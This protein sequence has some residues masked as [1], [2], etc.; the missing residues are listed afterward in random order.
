MSW[1]SVELEPEVGDWLDGLSGAEFG[2]V[3]FYVDLLAERGVLLSEPYTK[4]LDGKLRELRFDLGRQAIR[5]T[6][7]IASGRR[8]ILLTVF[9]KTRDRDRAQVARAMKAMLACMQA[10]HY[11]DEE[12]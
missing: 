7:W 12:E 6:C 8:I 10:G 3:A 4:Q 11:V 1:G 5:I 2:H 9:G